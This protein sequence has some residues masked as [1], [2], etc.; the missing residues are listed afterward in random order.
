[1]RRLVLD[2][3]ALGLRVVARL[4]PEA[5]PFAPALVEAWSLAQNPVTKQDVAIAMARSGVGELLDLLVA[6]GDAR[7]M[8]GPVLDVVTHQLV[9]DLRHYRFQ[10]QQH[11]LTERRLALATLQR[12]GMLTEEQRASLDARVEDPGIGDEVRDIR[13]AWRASRRAARDSNAGP[14]AQT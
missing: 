1:M 7:V 5:D 14:G 6:N 12:L 11:T 8:N 2:A 9:E 3:D 4:A 10:P 13:T